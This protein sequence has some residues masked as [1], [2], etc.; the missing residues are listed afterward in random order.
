MKLQKPPRVHSLWG[1]ST[2]RVKTCWPCTL[3]EL[4][5]KDKLALSYTW[6]ACQSTRQNIWSLSASTLS[7]SYH[8]QSKQPPGPMENHWGTHKGEDR[9]PHTV[10]GQS[11]SLHLTEDVTIHTVTIQL[12]K[13]QCL[14]EGHVKAKLHR[15][16]DMAFIYLR[17]VLGSE[18]SSWAPIYPLFRFFYDLCPYHV[19]WYCAS[20]VHIPKQAIN[21]YK[22]FLTEYRVCGNSDFKA[23]WTMKLYL[24]LS[25]CK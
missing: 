13:F 21:E 20:V 7:S 10:Q 25:K 16:A 15:A 2:W 22:A 24:G 1:N 9:F 11:L 23:E 8:W 14:A 5:H 4:C 18:T 19:S 3:V 12:G 6:G 17:G